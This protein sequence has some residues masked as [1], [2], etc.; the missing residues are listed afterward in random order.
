[1]TIIIETHACMLEL[2]IYSNLGSQL[3]NMKNKVEIVRRKKM[4]GNLKQKS[5]NE[6]LPYINKIHY[7]CVT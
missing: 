3:S 7:K 5:K 4:C 2:N 1:M 6:P